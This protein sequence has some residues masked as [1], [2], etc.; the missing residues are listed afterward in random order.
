MDSKEAVVSVYHEADP[1]F[2]MTVYGNR[3]KDNVNKPSMP[4]TR[5]AFFAKYKSLA[6]NLPIINGMSEVIIELAKNYILAINS[7][8]HAELIN[9]FLEKHHIKQYF[10]DV[11][12]FDTVTSKVEKLN[13]LIEKHGI[14]TNQ[15]VMITDT[16]GD[17]REAAEAKIKTIAVTWG[18]HDISILQEGNPNF[19]AYT[20]LEL[21]ELVANSF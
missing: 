20:P 1:T 16:L 4:L 13:T 17:L 19:L 8:G 18:L 6:P 11:L 7:S 9:Q 15:C 14:T 5:D 10:T 3:F 2:T 12:G 21:P